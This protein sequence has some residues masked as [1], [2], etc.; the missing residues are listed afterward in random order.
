MTFLLLGIAVTAC[1]A[2][3]PGSASAKPFAGIKVQTH[4]E[5]VADNMCPGRFGFTVSAEN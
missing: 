2:Q 3:A 4:C 5:T 1:R